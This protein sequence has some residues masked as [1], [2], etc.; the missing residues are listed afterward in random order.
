MTLTIWI[1]F[2]QPKFSY[3]ELN[4]D[5]NKKFTYDIINP[6]FTIDNDKNNI[7]IKANEGNFINENKILLKNEVNFLSNKFRIESSEVFF[8]KKNQTAYSKNNST[9]S[10]KKTEISSKGFEIK[11]AGNKIIFNGKT[12]IKINK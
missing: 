5:S 7:I 11:D 3:K 6:K 10:S 9:F 4:I 2:L 12:I 1:L 8:D